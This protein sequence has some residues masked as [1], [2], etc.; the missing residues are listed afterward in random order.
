MLY[1][2]R[3]PEQSMP[4]LPSDFFDPICV[5]CDIFNATKDWTPCIKEAKDL[6]YLE[7]MR[8]ECKTKD[9][10]ICDIS[11]LKASSNLDKRSS[12]TE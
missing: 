8:A 12:D 1:C 9:L 4:T 6:K 7:S 3:N 2:A 11:Q 5:A 10:K